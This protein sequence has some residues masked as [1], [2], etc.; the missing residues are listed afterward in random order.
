MR[1]YYVNCRIR[2]RQRR[3]RLDDDTLIQKRMLQDPIV[4]I[5]AD[6]RAH[7]AL[8]LRQLRPVRRCFFQ[9]NVASTSSK[10]ENRHVGSEEGVDAGEEVNLP[11]VSQYAA[12]LY[13][14]PILNY[15]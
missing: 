13:F 2:D 9:E 6:N 15:Y 11:V 7:L 1:D 10:V 5:H 4:N 14:R 8:D 3:V 12:R